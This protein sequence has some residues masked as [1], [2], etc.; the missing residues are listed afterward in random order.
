MAV[1]NLPL[2]YIQTPLGT[3][4]EGA[5]RFDKCIIHI[6]NNP[7]GG[8]QRLEYLSLMREFLV[9]DLGLNTPTPKL[10]GF[11]L[12]WFEQILTSCQLL[13]DWALEIALR[14]A[15]QQKLASSHSQSSHQSL[16][17]ENNLNLVR[18]FLLSGQANLADNE[19]VNTSLAWPLE[20]RIGYWDNILDERFSS[21][22]YQQD[23]LCVGSL[24]LTPMQPEHLH[25]FAWQFSDASIATLCNL[26]TFLSD[27]HWLDWLDVS[28]TTSGQ[29]LF[30]IMHKDWGFIGSVCL[31]MDDDVGFFYYWL[32]SDFQGHG[33]GP[34][35]VN[36]L[37]RIGTLYHGLKSCYAKVFKHNEISQKGV[38]KLGFR[39]LPYSF[40]DPHDHELLYYLGPD[41]SATS[42]FFEAQKT[43]LKFDTD[44]HI[45]PWSL[46]EFCA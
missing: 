25:G 45:I 13:S 24:Y 5:S 35:A 36:I 3:P 33:Y 23:D 17:I 37:L 42:L 28:R 14:K 46:D 11:A 34:E 9:H 44:R 39:Q 26:P 31:E 6:L 18:L 29:Y 8:D 30:A 19:L 21:Y 16:Q 41:K 20:H 1:L 40:A 10:L 12:E 15:L 27:Q 2:S 43:F 22:P 4:L 32:G 38:I 7:V